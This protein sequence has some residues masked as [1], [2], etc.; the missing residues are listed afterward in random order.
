MTQ[1]VNILEIIGIVAFAI[2]GVTVAFEEKMDIFGVAILGLTASVGGGMIRDLILGSNP[3]LVFKDP[4]YAIVAVITSL[5]CF[6]K[7]IRK[8]VKPNS[9]VV[10]LFDS[11]GLGIFTVVGV[12]T[13]LSLFPENTFLSI[14]VG[15]LTGTGGGVLRDIFARKTPAIFIKNFYATAALIGAIICSL[16]LK[17]APMNIAM[18][19]GA[20][21]II[22][23]RILAAKYRW[24]LPN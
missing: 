10:I 17:V 4:T 14:F 15:V 8:Y 5:I 9:P 11:I 23:L 1:L 20:I 3:P 19:I 13:S 2:S 7:P 18:F 21:V 6:I 24:K 22:I 12:T 16:L